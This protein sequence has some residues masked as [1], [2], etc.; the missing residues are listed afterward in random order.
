MTKILVLGA[1]GMLGHKLVETLSARFETFGAIRGAVS[2]WQHRP[3][4]QESTLYGGITAEDLESVTRAISACQP[5]IVVNCIGMVKQRR[6]AGDPVAAITVNALF[7]HRLARLCHARGIRLIHFS[8]DCVFSGRNGPYAETDPPDPIDLYG[9][10]KLLGEPATPGCLTLRT[11]FIGP[12][13]AA[14]TGLLEW[15]RAQRGGHVKGFTT[16]LFTGLTSIELARLVGDIVHDWP[17]LEGLWHVGADPITKYDLLTLINAVFDLG[18]VIE[19]DDGAPCDR[20]LDS[21]KFRREIGFSPK[22]W[23]DMIRALHENAV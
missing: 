8:T 18:V 15:F 16:A 22:A 1:T 13:L 9:R 23:P 21:A 11:S 6:E 14:P 2:D 5:E 7:P 10:T 4:F 12:E 17:A 19:P 20:R 3:C